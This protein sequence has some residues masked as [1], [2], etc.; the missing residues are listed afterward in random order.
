MS[1][2]K[3]LKDASILYIEDDAITRKQLAK[4]LKSK[5]KVLYTAVDGKKGFDSYKKHAPDIV[6]TDIEMPELNGLALARKIRAIS[7]S[8]Q[9]I[10]ITAYKKDEYLLQAVNLQLTQYLLK[11]LN[12][13]K[14]TD[15]LKLSSNYLNCNNA[16]TKKIIINNGYYDIYTKE[17]IVNEQIVNLSKHERSLIELLI[18]KHPAPASYESINAHVY[19]YCGSQNAMKLL[20]GSLRNKISKDSIVNI[21]GFGYKLNIKDEH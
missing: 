9:I 1:L 14:I 3:Q 12:I 17:M 6:I 16:N 2:Q 13:E 11:P 19:D 15:A 5:C 4:F 21:S 18:Q 8:T 7:L 10:I 20:A